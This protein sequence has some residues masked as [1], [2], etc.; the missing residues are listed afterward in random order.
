MIARAGSGWQTVLADLSLI[1]F[2]VTAAALSETGD[3]LVAAP[4]SLQGAQL[5]LYR[6]GDGAPPLE[7]WLAAQGADGRQQLTI[8]AQYAPGREEQ[9]LRQAEALLREAGSAAAGVRVVVE[10]GAGGVSASLAFDAPGRLLA[11]GLQNPGGPN[12]NQGMSR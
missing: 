5:A 2:M 11:Q 9:A 3:A 10:P 7:Q 1:L 8:V 6:A 12:R 4:V